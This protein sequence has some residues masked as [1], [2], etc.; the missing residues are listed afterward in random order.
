MSG[1]GAQFLWL[2]AIPRIFSSC[3]QEEQKRVSR[4][5]PRPAFLG[6]WISGFLWKVSPN[7]NSSMTGKVK[8]K[9]LKPWWGFLLP[10]ALCP[11]QPHSHQH[12]GTTLSMESRPGQ[13]LPF[14]SNVPS[15]DRKI[16]PKFAR[17]FLKGKHPLIS[18][19]NLLSC[20]PN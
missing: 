16:I 18:Q 6:K 3:S 11:A 15:F 5:Y 13:I 12:L 19:A 20:R 17:V 8:M 10:C 4:V 7:I 9:V 1:L 2:V 14:A